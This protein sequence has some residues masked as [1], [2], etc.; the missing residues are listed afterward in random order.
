MLFS[1]KQYLTFFLLS[2]IFIIFSYFVLD[3]KI[4]RYFLAHKDIYQ[5]IG[6]TISI[7]GQ[8]QW[9]FITAIVGFIIYKY[10]KKNEIYKQ[11]F[12]FLLYANLFSGLLSIV[13]KWFFGRVRP[14]GLRDGGDQ[15][16]FLLFQ[17]FDMGFIDKMQY[18]FSTIA[19]ATSKYSSFPSG[20]TVT[21]FTMF[22]YMSIIFPKYLYLWLSMAIIASGARIF[23]NDHFLS[24]IVAGALVGIFST[25][26]IYSK[27]KHQL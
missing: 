3:I 13:L 2:V 6:D 9:Y 15:F 24:D 5:S 1:K 14:W 7:S 12:L 23:A 10:F 4:A 17:N 25:I 21:I 16:G 19:H 18:Q 22:T 8:S 11:R 27:M 20:H 26:Y